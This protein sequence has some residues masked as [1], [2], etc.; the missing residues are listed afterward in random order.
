MSNSGKGIYK[1]WRHKETVSLQWGSGRLHSVKKMFCLELAPTIFKQ[2][3]PYDRS[4]GW[5]PKVEKNIGRGFT[6]FS[7]CMLM[8]LWKLETLYLEESMK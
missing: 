2:G 7:V 5:L 4:R 3:Y 6:N 8:E 1:A